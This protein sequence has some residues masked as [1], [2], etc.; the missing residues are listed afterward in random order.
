VGSAKRLA[1]LA[2][3]GGRVWRISF[4][5]DGRVNNVMLGG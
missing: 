2:E 1:E 4:N 5:R 3:A